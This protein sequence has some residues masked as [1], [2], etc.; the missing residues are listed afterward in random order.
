MILKL[1]YFMLSN[2]L[3][4]HNLEL[5][6]DNLTAPNC[7]FLESFICPSIKTDVKFCLSLEPLGNKVIQVTLQTPTKFC[8][9][10]EVK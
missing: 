3:L 4:E 1:F 9:L 5:H 7:E 10:S 6:R 8:T 2:S